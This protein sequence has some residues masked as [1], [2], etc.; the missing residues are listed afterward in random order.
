[1][2]LPENISVVDSLACQDEFFVN[3]PLDVKESDEHA[4][5][6]P[7]TCL[8]LFRLGEFGLFH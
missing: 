7:F 5:D 2:Q 6:F 8:A 4:L 3:N 1:M